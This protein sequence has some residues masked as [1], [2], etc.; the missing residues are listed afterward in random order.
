MENKFWLSILIIVIFASLIINLSVTLT[1]PTVFGDEGFYASRAQW[2]WENKQVPTIYHVQSQSEAFKNYFI[3]PPFM[4][5]LLASIFG[6]GGEILVK[7]FLPFVSLAT[8]LLVF[9]FVKKMYSKEA[10]VVSTVFLIA[11]PSFITYT[12]LLYVEAVSVFLITASL[13]FLY[14]GLTDNKKK[15]IILSGACAGVAALTDVGSFIMP[16]IYFLILLLYKI[17]IFDFIKKFITIF[18]VFL[19]VITPWYFIHNYSLAGTVGIPLA[20]RIPILSNFAKGSSMVITKDIE[21]INGNTEG[22]K[23]PT[24]IGG[25]TSDT[26]LKVGF[27]NYI[28]FAYS[29]FIIFFSFIGLIYVLL[30]RGKKEILILIWLFVLLIVNYYLTANG[31]AEDAARA[32]LATTVPISILAG[33]SVEKIYSEVKSLH[34]LGKYIAVV[35]VIMLILLSINSSNLKAQSL[36]PIKQFSTSFFQACDWI[37]QNTEQGSLLV[38]LWQHR[39]EYACK[40]DTLWISDPGIG[41]AILAHDNRT[42]AIFKAHG[43]DYIFIQKFSISQGNEGESYPLDFVKY[44]SETPSYQLVYETTAGCLGSTIGDCSMVYKTL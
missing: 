2:I 27:I 43:A 21:N 14:S 33:L 31:R 4:L 15:F 30:N 18:I 11:I 17:N 23:S 24:E 19:I 35:V 39:A 10:G 44:L 12:I 5:T 1:T 41:Q 26:I 36:K 20:E 25:G 9:L 42:Y 16:A 3:R 13:Y 28:E 37:K 40:R 6:I 29:Q 7:G 38:T 22:F 34:S 32:L 8:A